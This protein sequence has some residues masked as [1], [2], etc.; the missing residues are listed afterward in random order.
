MAT[1]GIIIVILI[2]VRELLA[3]ILGWGRSG[4][5]R[6]IAEFM[7]DVRHNAAIEQKW[8]KD[9]RPIISTTIGWRPDPWNKEDGYRDNGNN[10]Y[11]RLIRG[12][13]KE[14]RENF[15]KKGRQ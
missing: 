13:T 15:Y 4:D 14:Y 7:D 8:E 1:M 11:D 3:L 6:N 10:T 5:D 9:G 12:G 2:V